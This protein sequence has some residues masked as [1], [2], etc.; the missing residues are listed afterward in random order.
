MKGSTS[1]ASTLFTLDARA[2]F[3][4]YNSILFDKQLGIDILHTTKDLFIL[5]FHKELNTLSQFEFESHQSQIRIFLEH[6][7]S[8]KENF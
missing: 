2:K 4:H 1:E 3:P 8:T 5:A 6:F 7:F